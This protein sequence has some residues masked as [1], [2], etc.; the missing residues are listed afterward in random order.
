[1]ARTAGRSGFDGQSTMNEAGPSQQPQRVPPRRQVGR[2]RRGNPY[3]PPAG[4]R[5]KGPRRCHDAIPESIHEHTCPTCPL[6]PPVTLS[7]GT[8]SEVASQELTIPV[9]ESEQK[10]ELPVSQESA[11]NHSVS[12]V[13]N[14]RES[15]TSDQVH[16]T[17]AADP[18]GAPLRGSLQS[19]SH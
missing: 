4:R 2:P 8:Q 17:F 10:I 3:P 5:L 18:F 16:V 7:I 13:E 1:M 12:P 15:S 6:S 14:P 19:Y 11:Q 9:S